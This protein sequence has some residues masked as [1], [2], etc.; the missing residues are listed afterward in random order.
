GKVTDYQ[1]EQF[2]QTTAAEILG[3]LK[4]PAAV[5]PLFKTVMT[6]SKADV[7]ATASVALIKI[8]KNAV[9]FLLDA[10]AG[11]DADLV[12]YAKT[13]SGGSP[14]EAKSYVRWAA[15]VLGAIGRSDA[16]GPMIVALESADTDATRA[17]IARELT[18]L[19]PK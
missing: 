2:W 14:E 3:E 16:V 18:K 5:K 7:A 12:D 17:L 9:P 19:P 15:I 11:K 1:N 8:G 10:L 4:D 6:P 13:M